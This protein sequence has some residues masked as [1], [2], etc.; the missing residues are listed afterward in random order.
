M[1]P[2]ISILALIP[3]AAGLRGGNQGQDA[4]EQGRNADHSGVLA[5]N[6]KV[7]CVFAE[8]GEEE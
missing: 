8:E 3:S 2:G 4:S 1:T 6:M 5:L 7:E